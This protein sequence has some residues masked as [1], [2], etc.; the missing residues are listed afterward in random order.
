MTLDMSNKILNKFNDWYEKAVK[1]ELNNPNAMALA[2]S[3]VEGAP[4]VRIVLMKFFD[5]KGI[6]FFYPFLFWIQGGSPGPGLNRG[7]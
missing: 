3:T 1:E 2:T 6:V 5:K 7:K 4:S